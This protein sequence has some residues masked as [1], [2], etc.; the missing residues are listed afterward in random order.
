MRI[1]RIASDMLAKLGSSSKLN[2]KTPF[3]TMLR[4]EGRTPGVT[5]SARLRSCVCGSTIHTFG[6]SLYL[7][8]ADAGIAITSSDA[9]RTLPAIVA[10]RRMA[11]GG[12][13]ARH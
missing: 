7:V 6:A 2:A 11:A 10:P 8:G 1:H 5:L 12:S 3:L 13:V 9:S 4:D